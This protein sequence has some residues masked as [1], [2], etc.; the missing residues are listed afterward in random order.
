M[1]N[2][3]AALNTTRAKKAVYATNKAYGQRCANAD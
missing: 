2:K 1:I 3:E